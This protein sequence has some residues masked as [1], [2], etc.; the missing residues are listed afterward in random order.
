MTESNDTPDTTNATSDPFANAQTLTVTPI[1]TKQGMPFHYYLLWLFALVSL[2]L[3]IFIIKTLL[4][5]RQ[6]ASVAFTD[7][8]NSMATIRNGTIEYTVNINEEIPVALD[9]PVKFTVEVP[10][11]RTIPIDTVVQVPLQLPLVGERIIDVPIS[12]TVPL[13]LMIEIPVDQVVPINGTIPV[14]FDVPIKLLLNE[15]SFGEGIG[16][17]QTVLQQQAAALGAASTAP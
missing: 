14:R 1:P 4:D 17:L 3:N 16:Q 10:I 5:V 13:D 7:A 12:T 6:Q 9:V 8:A 2:G 11:K 15:T